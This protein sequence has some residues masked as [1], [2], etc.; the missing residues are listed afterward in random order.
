[1]KIIVTGS[2]GHIGKPLAKELTDKGNAV[3]V[4]SSKAVKQKDIEALNATAA[5]GSLE[6]TKFLMKIFSDADAVFCMVPPNFAAPDQVAYYSRLGNNY[7]QAIQHSGIKHVVHLSSYGADLDKGT[8]FILGAHHVENIL[9]R[10]SG[11]AVTHLRAMYFYYNLYHFTA[12]IKSAGFIGS[13]YGGN[14]RLVMV[15]PRDIAAVAAEE[16]QSKATG[17]KIRYVVSD[18]H[19][20]NETARILGAAIGKPD[21][22]WKV[23][24]DEQTLKNL[25]QNGMSK[26]AAE[27]LVELNAAIHNGIMLGDYDK[28]KPHVMGK[29]KTEDFA[30]EFA[31][32]YNR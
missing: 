4:I 12:M 14:D 19:T 13:N 8:G 7:L 23:F 16:L 15:D 30:Q 22:Q 21:L 11:I 31:K 2:L 25:E 29:V 6:D 1:M 28:H 18:E 27:M 9:N 17:K 24:S 3:T 10:L 32:M 26:H 20:A 5:I